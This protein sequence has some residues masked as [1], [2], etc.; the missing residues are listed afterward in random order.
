[1]ELGVLAPRL[2]NAVD[3]STHYG[4][5][6]CHRHCEHSFKGSSNSIL[7][8]LQFET[9]EERFLQAFEESRN[10]N[11]KPKMILFYEVSDIRECDL[12]R[13]MGCIMAT[14]ENGRNGEASY[15]K[16][17]MNKHDT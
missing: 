2:E 1:M 14:I 7:L 5:I 9:F 17:M 4:K 6:H 10:W 3:N 8:A 12:H 16:L 13:T 11:C 15:E